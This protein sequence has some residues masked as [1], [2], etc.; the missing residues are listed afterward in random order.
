MIDS[1]I[2]DADA[3]ALLR[4]AAEADGTAWAS[5]NATSTGG[6]TSVGVTVTI[7][8]CAEVTPIIDG[9]IPRGG[10]TLGLAGAADADIQVGDELCF[11]AATGPTGA[12]II[13]AG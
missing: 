7:D 10:G 1:A 13:T 3:A 12:P 2:L 9:T 4:L 5:F 6:N 11:E 8:V